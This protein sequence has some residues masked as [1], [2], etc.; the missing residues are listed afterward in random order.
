MPGVC[1]TAPDRATEYESIYVLRPDIEPE[2]AGKISTRVSDV[3]A[4]ENGSLVK[5][6]SWGRRKLAYPVRKYSRGIYYYLRFLGTGDIVAEFERNLRMQ[7]DAVLKFM[8]LKVRDEVT[9]GSVVVDPEEIRFA[10]V[11]PPGEGDAEETRERQLGLVDF[12]ES[13]APRDYDRSRE[14]AVRG[15]VA[16][17]D[18]DDSVGADDDEEK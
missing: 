17:V 9:I 5:V 12:H 11:E 18:D 10:V 1:T 16:D 2:A 15:D 14:R 6:E 7:R 13:R 4:R 8:T 3:I